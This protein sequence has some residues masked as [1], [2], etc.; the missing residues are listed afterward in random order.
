MKHTNYIDLGL[1]IDSIKINFQAKDIAELEY[2]EE[3]FHGNPV[4][5]YKLKYSKHGDPHN[6]AWGWQPL[7]IEI[8]LTDDDD[9]DKDYAYIAKDE[10][11]FNLIVN[12]ILIWMQKI[13]IEE[14]LVNDILDFS[15]MPHKDL[16]KRSF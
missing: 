10:S 2:A 13:E 16:F 15:G 11:E 5:Y 3:M 1:S 7:S 14:H 9:F 6:T 12:N 8:C 4:A